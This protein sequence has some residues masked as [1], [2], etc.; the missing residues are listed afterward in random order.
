MLGASWLVHSE[1]DDRI[2]QSFDRVE[3]RHQKIDLAFLRLERL[4]CNYL[5]ESID[6]MQVQRELLIPINQPINQ[7]INQSIDQPLLITSIDST[8]VD[9]DRD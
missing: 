3:L 4:V 2:A 6:G 1:N 5:V 9:G 8:I 7:S